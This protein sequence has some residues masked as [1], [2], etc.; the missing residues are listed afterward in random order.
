MSAPT[1]PDGFAPHFRK[2]NFTDPWEPIFSQVLARSVNLA[3]FLGEP[4]CN[5]RGLVHGGLIAGLS[6]NAMGLSCAAALRGEGREVSGLVTVSMN[7]EFAGAA[8]LGSWLIVTPEVVKLGRN[9]AFA[10]ALLT[11]EGA[12]IAVASASFKIG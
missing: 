9:L 5:S 10:R 12:T 3:V 6:D 2:S 8:R 1:P 4:H 11:A 7:T